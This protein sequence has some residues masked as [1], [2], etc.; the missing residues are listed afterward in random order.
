[1]KTKIL[2]THRI[3]EEI[4]IEFPY[5]FEHDLSD[6]YNSIIYGKM[7][8]GFCYTIHEKAGYDEQTYEFTKSVRGMDGSYITEEHKSSEDEYEDALGRMNEYI[9]GR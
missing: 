5:Y 3:E 7:T 8:Q 4:D 9:N 1:M 2:R 6:E